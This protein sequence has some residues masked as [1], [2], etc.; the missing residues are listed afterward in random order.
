MQPLERAKTSSCLR[1]PEQQPRWYACAV[2]SGCGFW[3]LVQNHSVCLSEELSYHFW[4]G[5]QVW[6]TGTG[7]SLPFIWYSCS[8]LSYFHYSIRVIKYMRGLSPRALASPLTIQGAV[9]SGKSRA[10]AF[11]NPCSLTHGTSTG[12]SKTEKNGKCFSQVI[13]MSAC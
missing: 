12:S 6:D 11:Q 3:S 1:W 7:H 2:V 9:R 10:T 5:V 13:C 8:F 4:E